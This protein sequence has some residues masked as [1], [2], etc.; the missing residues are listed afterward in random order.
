M[1]LVTD[2]VKGVTPLVIMDHYVSTQW[3]L[4]LGVTM[5]S[6]VTEFMG[7][8]E[9]LYVSKPMRWTLVVPYEGTMA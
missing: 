3:S 7:W 8:T 4:T 6:Q 9:P 5:T 1:A 2:V